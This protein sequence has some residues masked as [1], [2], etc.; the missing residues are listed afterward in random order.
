MHIPARLG[1]AR[2]GPARPGPPLPLELSLPSLERA[3]EGDD[4]GAAGPRPH[5]PLQ[6]R[7]T[8]P[9][10]SVGPASARPGS[11]ARIVPARIRPA[12]IMDQPAQISRPIPAG[13]A[14]R[15]GPARFSPARPDSAGIGLIPAPPLPRS[16]SPRH[17]MEYL[18]VP[19]AGRRRRRGRRRRGGRRRLQL[20]QDVRTG[21][22]AGERA[23]PA[24]GGA[25]RGGRGGGAEVGEDGGGA[26]GRH[27]GGGGL[28][29][30]AAC[31]SNIRVN[32]K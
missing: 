21:G 2:P 4:R 19:A 13:P 10:G 28:Q 11:A 20:D 25:G 6:R 22:R 9:P 16:P 30:G 27:G 3:G 31:D 17:G 7:A 5:A 14:S 8:A 26:E 18:S 23:G 15:P 29:A 24:A 32:Y 1:P 12:R